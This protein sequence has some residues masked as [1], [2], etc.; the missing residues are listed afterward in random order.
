MVSG[1]GQVFGHLYYFHNSE[2]REDLVGCGFYRKK[3][4]AQRRQAAFPRQGANYHKVGFKLDL[5]NLGL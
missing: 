4:Q 2:M 5:S 1:Q 3:R